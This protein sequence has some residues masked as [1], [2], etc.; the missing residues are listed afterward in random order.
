VEELKSH[1]LLADRPLL[2]GLLLFL[3]WMAFGVAL[4]QSLTVSVTWWQ[5]G[6]PAIGA[7]EA[8]WVVVFPVLLLIYIRY[9]SIFRPGCTSCATPDEQNARNL[10]PAP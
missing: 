6:F 2:R 5:G 10:P 3:L 8:V 7:G 4:I 1:R 9:L